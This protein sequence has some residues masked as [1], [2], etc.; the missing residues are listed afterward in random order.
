MANVRMNHSASD[1]SAPK[2]QPKSVKT[3][4]IYPPLS[5]A[6]RHRW[7]ALTKRQTK[8]VNPAL[9]FALTGMSNSIYSMLFYISSTLRKGIWQFESQ[10]N[11]L[12]DDLNQTDELE[13]ISNSLISEAEVNKQ[14]LTREPRELLECD[15]SSFSL[16]SS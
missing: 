5:S 3:T 15:E 16:K 9:F 7:S 1:R 11:N 6:I 12:P 13:S 14:V 4:A 8:E 10:H 2:D